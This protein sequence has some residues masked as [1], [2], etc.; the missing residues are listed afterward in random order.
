MK[1]PLAAALSVL[2]LA[3]CTTATDVSVTPRDTCR[4][5]AGQQFVGQRASSET[6]AAILEATD[7]RTL[8]WVAPGMMVTAD[9]GFGRV[10]VSYD[11]AMVITRVSCG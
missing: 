7:T 8:R 11:E 5:D 1:I 3:A 4:R 6:G 10:T 2:A 9:Y